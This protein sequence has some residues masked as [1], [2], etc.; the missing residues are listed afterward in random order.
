MAESFPP[1][2]LLDAK[3]CPVENGEVIAPAGPGFGTQLTEQMVLD[4]HL[5]TYQPG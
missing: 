4:H 3:S 1:G 5:P 2:P